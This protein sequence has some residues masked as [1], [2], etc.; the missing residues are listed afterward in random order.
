MAASTPTGKR[1]LPE[2]RRFSYFDGK[3][4]CAVCMLDD[5]PAT[6]RAARRDAS[7]MAWHI[8]KEHVEE[9]ACG[10]ASTCVKD[11]EGRPWADIAG[12]RH[13]ASISHSGGLVAIAIAIDPGLLVGVDLEY[14]D[15]NRSISEMA[16][17]LGLSPSISVSDFYAAW[18]R[19]EAIFKATGESD[20]IAQP[21]IPSMVLQ[22]PV[23]FASSLV[24]TDA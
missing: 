16:P 15:P 18:C 6:R 9:I 12:V 8:L 11:D 4:I 22:L 17:L 1:N 3:V 10:K 2:V 14:C 24:V 20:P 19:Y 21:A 5:V 13:G 23:N 7:L